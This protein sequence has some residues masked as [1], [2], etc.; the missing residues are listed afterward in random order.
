MGSTYIFNR[1]KKTNSFLSL[2]SSKTQTI[3]QN[4]IFAKKISYSINKN[5]C[6]INSQCKQNEQGLN[7]KL[8]REKENK[9]QKVEDNYQKGNYNSNDSKNDNENLNSMT[10]DTSFN[11]ALNNKASNEFNNKITKID[12]S[13]SKKNYCNYIPKIYEMK[14]MADKKPCHFPIECYL[15]ENI[16]HN[17][18]GNKE[19]LD[20]KE[21]NIFNSNNDSYKSIDRK[22]HLLLNH[23]CIKKNNKK[24][25][26]SFTIKYR[27]K[28]ITFLYFK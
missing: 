27:H 2:S 11:S 26:N 15:G 14:E 3:I 23:L 28:N 4:L 16:N 8:I 10:K 25:I 1:I 7:T 21:K 24:I 19:F 6:S 12:F 5:N 20:I 18:I 13:F 9:G 17:E 22:D